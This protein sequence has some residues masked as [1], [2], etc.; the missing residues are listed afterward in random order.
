[1]E[2]MCRPFFFFLVSVAPHHG[3]MGHVALFCSEDFLNY[4]LDSYFLASFV[5]QLLSN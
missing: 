1:M 4:Y 2:S 5:Q 3:F